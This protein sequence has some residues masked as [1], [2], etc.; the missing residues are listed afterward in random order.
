MTRRLLLAVL[1]AAQGELEREDADV[2]LV[3]KELRTVLDVAEQQEN[4]KVSCESVPV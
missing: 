3:I 2:R 1:L 4:E